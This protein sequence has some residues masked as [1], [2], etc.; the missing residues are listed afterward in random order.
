V[1]Q[2]KVFI[3]KGLRAVDACRPRAV[4]VEEVATLNHE[5]GDLFSS[6][7]PILWGELQRGTA[8][9]NAM[10]PAALVALWPT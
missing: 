9:H 6:L 5:V 4:A 8:A 2:R 7:V 10:E 3:S 1:P